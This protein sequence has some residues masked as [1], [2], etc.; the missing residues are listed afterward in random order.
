VDQ[1][2]DEND[3]VTL[4]ADDRPFADLVRD[5]ASVQPT[6]GA[7]PSLA[8]TC[9]LAAALVEMA[10]A[11][12]L[13]H[14]PELADA[15]TAE[16]DRATALRKLALSLADKDAAAYRRVLAAQRDRET[17]DRA[18]RIRRALVAAA[19]PIVAIAEAAAEVTHLA[20]DVAARARGGVRGEAVTAAALGCAVAEAGVSVVEL[21][22]AGTP[23]DPRHARVHQAADAARANRQR[24]RAGGTAD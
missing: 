22:L 23:D 13:R 7:G 5:V 6:P 15:I 21:N 20:A 9:A 18:R 17:P 24:A 14:Q 16:R 2:G 10:N 4:G 8:W 1:P 12:V 11:V 19:D 3:Q